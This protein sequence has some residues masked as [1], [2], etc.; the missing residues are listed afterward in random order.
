MPHMMHCMH[1]YSSTDHCYIICEVTHATDLHSSP[2]YRL[3]TVMQLE[4]DLYK[5]RTERTKLTSIAHICILKS[6]HFDKDLWRPYSIIRI[7]W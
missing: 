5:A 4:V 2:I 1:E 3:Y 6:I 7:S